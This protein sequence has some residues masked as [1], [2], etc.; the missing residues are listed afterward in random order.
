MI[1]SYLEC[2]VI[3]F[4]CETFHGDASCAGLVE[5]RKCGFVTKCIDT[6]WKNQP[7]VEVRG[8]LQRCILLYVYRVYEL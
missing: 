3:Q 2:S 7:I 4:D 6:V 1:I 5:A 8:L